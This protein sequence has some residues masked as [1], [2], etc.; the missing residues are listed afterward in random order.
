LPAELSR[1]LVVIKRLATCAARVRSA[2]AAAT[3]DC[4]FELIDRSAVWV[5][6]GPGGIRLDPADIRNARATRAHP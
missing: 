4:R 5:A 2:S 6:R 3:A 1:R